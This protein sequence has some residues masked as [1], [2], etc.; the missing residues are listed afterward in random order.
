MIVADA[1]AVLDLVLGQRGARHTASALASESEV[2][3]PEHFHVE[4]IAG[5]RN[6]R[7]RAELTESDA[8]RALEALRRLR[9]VRYPVLPMAADVWALRDELAAYDA[10]YLA[11]AMRLDSDL[12]TSD[13][14]LAAAARNR[15]RLRE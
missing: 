13:R 5:L 10:A 6:L 15:G 12:L 1:S 4:A 8:Q 9:V 7:L 2:H 3:V 11:L 14:G